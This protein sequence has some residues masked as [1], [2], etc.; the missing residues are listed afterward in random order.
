MQAAIRIPHASLVFSYNLVDSLKKQFFLL[1]KRKQKF[2][3]PK[4]LLHVLHVTSAGRNKVDVDSG[5]WTRFN[6]LDTALWFF[7][8]L[9]LD[10]IASAISNITLYKMQ[11]DCSGIAQYDVQTAKFSAVFNPFFLQWQQRL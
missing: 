8:S 6:P 10:H 1:G 4:H 11:K 2:E 5:V 7:T 9:Y 3:P